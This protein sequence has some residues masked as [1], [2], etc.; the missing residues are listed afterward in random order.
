MSSPP[1]TVP[2]PAPATAELELPRAPRRAPAKRPLAGRLRP[3]HL[4]LAGVLGLSAV[5]NTHR[6]SQNGY[7]NTFYAAGVKSMLHSLHNFLFVSSDPGGLITVDKPPLALWVQ[8][9]S[10]KLFGFSPLSLLLPEALAGVLSVLVLYLILARRLG[11]LPALV[12]A[13]AL[14]REN[15]VDPVLILLMVLACAAALRAIESGRWRTLLLCGLLVGLAFNTKTLA[16]YLVV[17]AIALAY[18]ICAPGSIWRRALQLLAAGVL[19]AVVSFSWIAFVELTPA[20]QRPFVGSSTNN[21]EL[22]LTFEY[23]GFGRVEG[24]YG[25]P[26]G[27]TTVKQGAIPHVVLPPPPPAAHPARPVA[28]APAP[29]AR[30]PAV[31][32]NGGVLGP[33][34]REATPTPFGQSPKLLRLFGR[35]LGDQGGWLLPFAFFGLLAMALARLGA[36]RRRAARGADVAANGRT[37]INPLVGRRDP[38]LALTLVLG[39]WFITEALVLSFSKGIVHPYYVSALAPG[40]GAMLG[41]GVAAFIEL[42]KGRRL[43]PRLLLAPCAVAAT[44]AVQVLFLDKEHYMQWFIPLLVAGA[45]V[46]LLVLAAAA[47]LARRGLV[48]PAVAATAC[49]LL[50]APAAYSSTTWSAPTEGTFPV[51]GPKANYGAGG[52]G[53]PAA[54]LRTYTA[55]IAYVRAHHPGTRWAILTDAADTASPF[56]LLGLPAGSL[57]GYSG[58]DP[59]IDGRQLA[60]YVARGQARYVVLGGAYATRGGNK[61]T[62]AVLRACPQVPFGV[63]HDPNV[64]VSGLV[65]FD[66]ARHE[67]GLRD[68]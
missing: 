54:H 45:A 67:A 46:G 59:A 42:A 31:G 55:L 51:A 1:Q 23:N 10:A 38:R 37:R 53:V 14:S 66:C 48:A 65:L 49:L 40:T 43:D 15:A 9:A 64:S 19:M 62:A 12:G 4:A 39:G 63:W 5:L 17:P 32:P 28:A 8:A 27:Q 7:A 16:A 44:V 47:L 60:S 58:A 3:H 52:V 11:A 41:A 6:L 24:E 25:G 57:A 56:I 2:D 18:L 33:N 68:E 50:I 26:G 34:G 22:G 36:W 61:A 20:S 29:A 21:T 30:R 13:S 35:G